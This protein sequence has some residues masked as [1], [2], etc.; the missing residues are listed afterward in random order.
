[1]WIRRASEHLEMP[2]RNGGGTTL[3]VLREPGTPAAFDLR[4]SFAAVEEDGPFS[5]FDGYDRTIV[6]VSGDMLTLHVGTGEHVVRNQLRPY[7]PYAFPGEAEVFSKVAGPS[8]DFNVMVRRGVCDAEVGV[9]QFMPGDGAVDVGPSSSGRLLV[10]VLDGVME[11][12]ENSS[13]AQL[14]PLDVAEVTSPV[15]LRSVRGAV[16]ALVRVT[17]G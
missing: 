14:Q 11:V 4:L 2:W 12:A 3:E 13:V 10:V 5:V 8:V 16:V 7:E 9:Q 6:L 17:A 1:M 15:G